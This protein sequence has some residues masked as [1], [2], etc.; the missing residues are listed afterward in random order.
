MAD[1]VQLY[2]ENVR[3]YYYIVPFPRGACANIIIPRH[4]CP[5]V[6]KLDILNAI[7]V[8]KSDNFPF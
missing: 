1:V 7:F 4:R 8:I 3:L 6:I 2:Y 5:F